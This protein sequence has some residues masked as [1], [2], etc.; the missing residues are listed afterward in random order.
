VNGDQANGWAERIRSA[1]QESL[2]SIIKCGRLPAEAKASL[3]HGHFE[4]MVENELPFKARTAQMLMK[5]AADQ[6]LTNANYGSLLPPSWRTLYEL[7]RLDDEQFEQGITDGT[8]NPEMQRKD[9]ARGSDTGHVSTGNERYT[10]AEWIERARQA[11]GSIDVDPASCSLAQE[12]VQAT[13]WYD[14]GCDGLGFAVDRECLVESALL[15][16]PDRQIS[17]QAAQ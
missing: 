14:R 6:R 3:P 2:S 8:I 15:P 17:G 9:I 13:V 12:T 11:L 4:A 7:T 5:I 1:W 10:T 16:R